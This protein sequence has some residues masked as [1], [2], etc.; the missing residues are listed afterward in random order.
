MKVIGK[1]VE[2]EES[3]RTVV[4]GVTAKF[5]VKSRSKGRVEGCMNVDGN[6]IGI[7]I[8]AAKTRCLKRRCLRGGELG[9][10]GWSKASGW[11][12][13]LSCAAWSM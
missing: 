8:T 3:V 11:S 12:C 7:A 5:S 1:G 13:W 10:E 6:V 4:V 9:E 2:G